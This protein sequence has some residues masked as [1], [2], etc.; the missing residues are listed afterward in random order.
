MV[1]LGREPLPGELDGLE[2]T[3]VAYDA[4][5]ILIDYNSWAGGEYWT[6][7]PYI[8]TIQPAAEILPVWGWNP[9]S[10]MA[11]INNLTINDLKG[12]FN[13]NVKVATEKWTYNQFYSWDSLVDFNTGQK[14]F[15]KQWILTP[16]QI[17]PS[18]QLKP[19][20][21]DTQTVL[22]NDLGLT[23]QNVTGTSKSE[24]A[25]LDTLYKSSAGIIGQETFSPLI[26]FASRMV[27][28]VALTHVGV[29][30]VTINGI[31]PVTD[32]DAV[33]NGTYP[34]TRKIHLITRKYVSPSIQAFKDYLLSADGQNVLA[35]AGL[36][37]LQEP[38]GSTSN[39]A[40][41]GT[42]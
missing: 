11:G 23:Q 6:N 20:I 3:V 12:I 40:S 33:Y 32:I 22:Y 30:V 2:D 10:K 21:F 24:E 28:Q 39:L 29:A 34:L 26:S 13:Y 19:G 7:T 37:P 1:I 15:F 16:K 35:N 31:N 4:V 36:L 9:V 17:T 38:T 42:K 18:L 25:S 8:D 5:C 41:S 27:T 14:S